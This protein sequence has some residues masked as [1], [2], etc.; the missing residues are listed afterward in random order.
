MNAFG[1]RKACLTVSTTMI[2]GR[3]LPLAF[4]H[5]HGIQATPG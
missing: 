5:K 1:V 4:V 3:K 2:V